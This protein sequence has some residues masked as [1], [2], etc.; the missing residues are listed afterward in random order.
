MGSLW[1][2]SGVHSC[3]VPRSSRRRRE[4][5]SAVAPVPRQSRS[6]APPSRRGRDRS[7]LSGTVHRRRSRTITK[8]AGVGLPAYRRLSGFTAKTISS[9][10]AW[11]ALT[12]LAPRDHAHARRGR[13]AERQR[14]AE[15][16]FTR[17]ADARQLA[18][19]RSASV[20]ATVRAPAPAGSCRGSPLVPECG[21][22]ADS[23]R[24]LWCWSA[25]A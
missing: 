7:S 6:H 22:R 16:D 2:Q 25:A 12:H 1:Q 8:R 17:G 11:A 13:A 4:R 5:R 3:L 19:V 14:R 23:D 15:L 10:S 20:T 24:R 9:R 18:A 21:A